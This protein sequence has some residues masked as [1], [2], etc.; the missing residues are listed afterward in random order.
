MY[1]NVACLLQACC[2]FAK[3]NCSSSHN[4]EYLIF[5]LPVSPLLRPQ[6]SAK[7]ESSVPFRFVI[8]NS[9]RIPVERL[10]SMPRQPTIGVWFS[11]D[12]IA[13]SS[14]KGMKAIMKDTC[15]PFPHRHFGDLGGVQTFHLYCICITVPDFLP[16]FRY[17]RLIHLVFCRENAPTPPSVRCL[18]RVRWKIP[19]RNLQSLCSGSQLTP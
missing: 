15:P 16:S 19:P 7:S 9:C 4:I 17:A 13:L 8:S 12:T 3:L 1:K 11:L 10:E 18:Y 2:L 14:S 6:A 5:Y